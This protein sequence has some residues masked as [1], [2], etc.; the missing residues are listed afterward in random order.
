MNT[1]QANCQREGEY[2]K[3]LEKRQ[4]EPN[5]LLS[6]SSDIRNADDKLGDIETSN[7]IFVFGEF[8]RFVCLREPR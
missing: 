7:L 2:K 6:S 1:L 5:L 3:A 4:L 8:N